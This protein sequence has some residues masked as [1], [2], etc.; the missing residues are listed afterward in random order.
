MGN[1]NEKNHGPMRELREY[2]RGVLDVDH[3]DVSRIAGLVE[4]DEIREILVFASQVYDPSAHPDLPPSFW[5]TEWAQRLVELYGTEAAADAIE[6]G[7]NKKAAYL[8]GIPNYSRD[9]SG[10]DAED[11]LEDWLCHEDPCK[12][13]YLAALMGRGKT[14]FAVRCIQAVYRHYKRARKIAEETDGLDP[15]NVP[16]PEFATN[17]AIDVPEGVDVDWQLIDN[18]EDLVEWAEEGSSDQI[19]WFWF[20][21]ASSELTAQ[22]GS[23]A[24]KVVK[25]MNTLVKK[26]RKNGINIGVIGHDKGDVHILFRSLADF[27]HKPELK[28]VTVF[29]GINK[30]EPVNPKFSLRSVPDATWGYDTEDMAEWSWGDEDAEDGEPADGISEDQLLETEYRII[31]RTYYRNDDLSYRAVGDLVGCGKDKVGDA[32]A[33]FDPEEL[34]LE[35]SADADSEKVAAAD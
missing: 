21:E 1:E 27:V 13:V 23:N 12:V 18:H 35:V 19:R 33:C 5:D 29:E 2:V 31:A 26:A 6:S 24:Q 17:F 10:V 30:R 16:T 4:D 11:E 14:S 7:D 20:D 15:K 3:Q 8:T 22:D 25:K 28:R 9:M 34:G 32:V